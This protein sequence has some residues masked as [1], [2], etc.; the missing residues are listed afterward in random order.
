MKKITYTR[1]LSTA[2]CGST[3]FFGLHTIFNERSHFLAAPEASWRRDFDPW[4]SLLFNL[5]HYLKQNG[6]FW[7]VREYAPDLGSQ[8]LPGCKGWHPLGSKKTSYGLRTNF[9]ERFALVFTI[10]N[11]FFNICCRFPSTTVRGST[12]WFRAISAHIVRSM[13]LLPRT[14]HGN[15]NP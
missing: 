8:V 13:A 11:F 6:S 3:T 12:S 5:Y 7:L 15:L 14:I 9:N 4:T 2:L 1:Y 10:V